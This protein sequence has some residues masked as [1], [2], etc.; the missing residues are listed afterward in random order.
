MTREYTKWIDHDG[1][2]FPLKIVVKMHEQGYSH[3]RYR[4]VPP[5]KLATPYEHAT[6]E[7]DTGHPGWTW[8]KSGWFGRGEWVSSD[9]SYARIVKY[10]FWRPKHGAETSTSEGVDLLKA[11]AKGA[12]EP[13]QEPFEGKP[14]ETTLTTTTEGG[15]V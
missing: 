5:G 8:K 15:F 11:I 10:V 6:G 14:E 9:P 13:A 2:G 3:L 7:V 4:V 1:K 12:L